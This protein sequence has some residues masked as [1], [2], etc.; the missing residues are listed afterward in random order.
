MLTEKQIDKIL[1]EVKGQTVQSKPKE[2]KG[3]NR[4]KRFFPA[5][6]TAVQMSKVITKLLAEWKDKVAMF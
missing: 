4:F 5:D 3:L 2:E 6:Y 1:S